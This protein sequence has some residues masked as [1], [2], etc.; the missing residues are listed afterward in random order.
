MYKSKLHKPIRLIVILSMLMA[1]AACNSPKEPEQQQSQGG[2]V[3]IAPGAYDSVDTAVV[4]AKQEKQNKIT[5]LN[6][7]KKLNYTLNYDG[8]T[9]FMD[10]YGEQIAVSQL[11]EG[12][13][14]D[15]QFLKEGK[16]IS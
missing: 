15:V 6:L 8:T 11:D 1:L 13:I 3:K 16:K 14:V 2:F 10:K 4:V 5:F 9:K 12:E 7:K